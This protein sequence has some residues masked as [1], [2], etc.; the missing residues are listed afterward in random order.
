MLQPLRQSPPPAQMRLIS[1]INGLSA[2]RRRAL[3][4]VLES[5]V[6]SMDLAE[7]PVGFFFE[8]SG[9]PPVRRRREA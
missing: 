1:A 9:A 8:E 7:G 3:A 4:R 2:D 5:V 6:E